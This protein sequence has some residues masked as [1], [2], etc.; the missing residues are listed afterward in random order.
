M[1]E[2][3]LHKKQDKDTDSPEKQK[4]TP[5]FSF[6]SLESTSLS[7]ISSDDSSKHDFTVQPQD[8]LRGKKLPVFKKFQYKNSNKDFYLM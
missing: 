4:K 8:K 1:M 7:N 2:L 6:S 3:I 5:F